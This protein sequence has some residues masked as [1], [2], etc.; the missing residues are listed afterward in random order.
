VGRLVFGADKKCLPQS[1][2]GTQNIPRSFR[3]H[4]C[5]ELI[6][7]AAVDDFDKGFA[8]AFGAHHIDCGSVSDVDGFSEI[9]VGGDLRGKLAIGIEVCGQFELVG[10]GEPFGKRP[11]VI[12][13]DLRLVLKDVITIVVA[14]IIRARI[15]I[16]GGDS[17]VERP[18]VKGKREVAHHKRDIVGAGGIFKRGMDTAAIGAFEIF[19]GDDCDLSAGWRTQCRIDGILREREGCEQEY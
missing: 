7:F 10:G 8:L 13:R 3:L 19:E 6:E 9:A 12:F 4:G 2:R 11:K 14:E 5:D 15:E 1:T 17:G 18:L 16:A